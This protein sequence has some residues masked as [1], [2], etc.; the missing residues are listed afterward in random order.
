MV[1]DREESE[2]KERQ[3]KRVSELVPKDGN[4]KGKDS[5]EIF[6][7]TP[8]TFSTRIRL[9][10]FNQITVFSCYLISFTLLTLS[11]FISLIGNT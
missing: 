8:P 6:G 2:R 5:K 7:F 1:D 9:Y 3:R 10:F 4:V 11:R